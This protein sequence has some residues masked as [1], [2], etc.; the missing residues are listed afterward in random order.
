MY[1]IKK[2]KKRKKEMRFRLHG[3]ELIAFF[4]KLD[5]NSLVLN[6]YALFEEY[7]GEIDILKEYFVEEFIEKNSGVIDTFYTISNISKNQR[8]KN[9]S[10]ETIKKLFYKV[11]A[12]FPDLNFKL[13]FGGNYFRIIVVR[14]EDFA[15]IVLEFDYE[16]ELANS[17]IAVEYNED[18]NSK[19]KFEFERQN[20][21]LRVV[22]KVFKNQRYY[23]KKRKM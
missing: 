9:P 6:E 22:N 20:E 4:S 17:S 8:T 1:I 14:A 23:Y 2:S 11:T 7:S 18:I 10:I 19:I 15:D 13:E 5:N 3:S 12:A 21:I 16:L